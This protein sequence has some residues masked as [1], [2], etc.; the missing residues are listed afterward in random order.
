MSIFRKRQLNP[1]QL[2][3]VAERRFGDADA[4]RQTG[5]NARANGAMY[6]GGFVVELLLKAKLLERFPWLQNASSNPNRSPRDQRLWRLCYQSHHLDEILDLLPEVLAK[7][8]KSQQAQSHRLTQSLKS[9]CAQWTI[10]ARY[11]P[12]T[13]L[14]DEASAF[15]DRIKELKRCLS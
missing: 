12:E 4:L 10:Y 6:L 9:V 5:K 13:A 7:L 14:M 1:S 3:T 15:L 2:R 11:S 8:S